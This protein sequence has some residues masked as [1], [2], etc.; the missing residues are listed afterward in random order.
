MS[1]PSSPAASITGG[2]LDD[3][4]AGLLQVIPLHFSQN[5]VETA[6]ALDNIALLGRVQLWLDPASHVLDHHEV[7]GRHRRG[8]ARDPRGALELYLL[9]ARHA[10]PGLCLADELDAHAIVMGDSL[11][12]VAS[13]SL[14]NLEIISWALPNRSSGHWLAWTRA[15]VV[16]IARRIGH[17]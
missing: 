3:D 10:S 6:K 4:E 14:R 8:V 9:Q 16:A 11:G 17:L 5:E 1:S 7:V 2:R 12:Q 15:E 13:Q